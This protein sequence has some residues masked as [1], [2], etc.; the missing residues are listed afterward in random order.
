MTILEFS[1]KKRST[2]G[3]IKQAKREVRDEH[4]VLREGRDREAEAAGGHGEA[5]DE[6]FH[7]EGDGG[8]GGIDGFGGRLGGGDGTGEGVLVEL[9]RD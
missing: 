2:G 7:G 4:R 8:F 1:T 5:V 6:G 3:A 9:T